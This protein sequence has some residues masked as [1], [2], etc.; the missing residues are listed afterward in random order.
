MPRI[1][2]APGEQLREVW[3]YLSRDEARDL[4]TALAF[5]DDEDLKDHEWHHHIGALPHGEL[6]IA[7]EA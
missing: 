4:L 5:W 6:T 2:R 7:I 1:E 3:V